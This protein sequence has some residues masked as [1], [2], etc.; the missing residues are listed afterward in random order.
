MVTNKTSPWLN[1]AMIQRLNERQKAGEGSKD[2]RQTDFVRPVSE[3]PE[4][5][6]I[7]NRRQTLPGPSAAPPEPR[8]VPASPEGSP[9]LLQD[10][11]IF[12]DTNTHLQPP[13]EREHNPESSYSPPMPRRTPSVQPIEPATTGMPSSAEVWNTATSAITPRPNPEARKKTPATFIDRQ[14]HAHRV[15]PISLDS[16]V[17]RADQPQPSR[18][19]TNRALEDTDSDDE[20]TR[21]ERAIDPSSKRAQK[22]TDTQPRQHKR[23]RI[24]ETGQPATEPQRGN[25]PPIPSPPAATAP[26]RTTI[27]TATRDNS[28]PPPRRPRLSQGFIPESGKVRS[29]WSPEEDSRLIRLIRECG[30]SWADLVRLNN[31][32]PVREGEVRIDRDQV[33]YKD[34]ARNLKIMYY[35]C[36]PFPTSSFTVQSISMVHR[37]VANDNTAKEEKTNCPDNSS[38]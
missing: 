2:R 18:K 14:E 38:T 19:R 6:S 9:T 1:S 12:A 33:Q 26:A 10:E 20:F 16:R 3:H 35:R 23:R 34:R 36:V 4:N 17:E 27:T 11:D 22:P 5:P 25:T 7:D 37:Q 15:S 24:D 8:E 30:T 28:P 31:A 29:R 32:Q 13:G 21:Y